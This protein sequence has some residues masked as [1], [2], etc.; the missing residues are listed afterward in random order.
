MKEFRVWE[1]YPD[2]YDI[3]AGPRGRYLD[4]DSFAIFNGGIY[5]LCFDEMSVE[6]FGTLEQWIGLKD[7]E[8][9]KIFEGDKIQDNDFLWVIKWSDRYHGWIA[10]SEDECMAGDDLDYIVAHNKVVGTIHEQS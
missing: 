1:E 5:R 10:D 8:G 3:F 7:S 6:I 2:Q 4:P 9:V